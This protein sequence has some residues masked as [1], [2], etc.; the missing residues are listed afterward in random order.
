MGEALCGT[1]DVYLALNP[2]GISTMTRG[3]PLCDLDMNRTFPGSESGSM[4]DCAGRVFFAR[5]S[6]LIDGHEVA[7]RILPD[8]CG[9]TDA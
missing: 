6:L 7:F 9:G 1:V 2:L 4:S 3:I 5:R 8:G